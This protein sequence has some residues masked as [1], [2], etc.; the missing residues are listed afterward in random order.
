M[1][2]PSSQA[3][4]GAGRGARVRALAVAVCLAVTL[5]A[6]AGN[7]SYPRDPEGTLDRVTGGTMRAGVSD[8]R[9]WVDLSGERPAGV[10]VALLERFARE[11]GARVEWFE[12]SESELMGALE[13]H[14]LDVV[15]AGLERSAPWSQSVALTRPY[16]LDHIVVG[17]PSGAPVPADI[18]GMPIAAEAGSD[19]AGLLN[20]TDAVVVRVPDIEQARG[21]P[22]AVEDWALNDLGL[23]YAGVQLSDRRHVMAVPM[24]ENGWQTALE[25][26]LLGLPADEVPRLLDRAGLP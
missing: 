12:G 6:C 19:A 9:P 5:G 23:V 25:R 24:G 4:A 2:V 17:V 20:K 15:A 16:V 18:A 14:E 22:A 3:R 8:H 26:F 1:A 11:L 10:E 21:R 13:R 7:D